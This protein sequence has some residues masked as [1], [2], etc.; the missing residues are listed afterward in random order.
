[1]ILDRREKGRFPV[2]IF[3]LISPRYL[4]NFSVNFEAH[5]RLQDNES[6]WHCV[7]I[8]VLVL[9]PQYFVVIEVQ[10]KSSFLLILIILRSLI[11]VLMF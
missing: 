11:I 6:F 9:S 3:F 10:I 8:L 4:S 7:Q 5:V 2:K 1:M